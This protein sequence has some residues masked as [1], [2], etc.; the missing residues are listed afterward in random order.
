VVGFLIVV[1]KIMHHR[2]FVWLLHRHLW[3]LALA[4]YLF[5]LTPIDRLVTGYNTRRI[6]GGDPAPSVQI[7]VHP[8]GPE[9]ILRLLPLLECD[10][11]II[12]EGVHALLFHR[13]QEYEEL[14]REREELGWTARQLADNRVLEGLRRARLQSARQQPDALQ[15]FYEYAHQW[16]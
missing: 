3:A 7:S 11:E 15:R 6:M 5:A 14:S 12:R 1:W 13:L 2:D 4:I 8:I 10:D 16:Y 9:G